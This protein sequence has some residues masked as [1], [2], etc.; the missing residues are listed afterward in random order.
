VSQQDLGTAEEVMAKLS[1]T[2]AG[3]P[4]R[5][6]HKRFWDLAA[7]LVGD[8]SGPAVAGQTPVGPMPGRFGDHH[9]R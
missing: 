2:A 1:G 8:A 9:R 4:V 7:V 5:S 6:Q 3:Q